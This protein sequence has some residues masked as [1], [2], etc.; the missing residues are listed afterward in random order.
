[1]TNKV[2]I[3]VARAVTVT[4]DGFGDARIFYYRAKRLPPQP[5]LIGNPS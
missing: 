4:K 2:C 1:M 5:I 3:F